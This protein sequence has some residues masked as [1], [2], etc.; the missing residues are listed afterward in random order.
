MEPHQ[1]KVLKDGD[2]L[3]CGKV[4]F[5][6]GIEPNQQE[7]QVDSK[8]PE[9][10]DSL[11]DGDPWQETDVAEFLNAA[12]D[13]DREQRYAGIRTGNRQ[14]KFPSSASANSD[15]GNTESGGTEADEWGEMEFEDTVDFLTDAGSESKGDI[16]AKVDSELAVGSTG[17]EQEKDGEKRPAKSKAKMPRQPPKIPKARRASRF[18]LQAI[19]F[20]SFSSGNGQLWKMI[21]AVVLTIGMV[22]FCCYTTYQVFYGVDVRVV[23]GID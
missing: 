16:D 18:S 5:S 12:D 21:G 10:V 6:V 15:D 11:T 8:R 22:G 19:S 17:S 20:P 2:L 3:R 1:W 13:A 7:N 9:T 14:S 23:R 4:L